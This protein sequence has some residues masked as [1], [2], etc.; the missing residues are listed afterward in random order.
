MGTDRQT[1]ELHLSPAAEPQSPGYAPSRSAIAGLLLALI[2]A[3]SPAAPDAAGDRATGRSRVDLPGPWRA[4][5]MSPG[6][7]LPFTLRF[8]AGESS[9]PAVA[10][11][12]QEEVPFS[13]VRIDGSRVVLH[14]EGYDSVIDAR[15]SND[16]RLLEGEWSRTSDTGRSRLPFRATRGDERRFT[17]ELPDASATADRAAIPS[18]AGT[19]SAR[20]VD[21]EGEEPARAEFRQD[22]TRVTGTFLLPTGDYRYLEGDYRDGFLRLSCFDGAHVFLFHARARADGY[23]EGDFWSRDTY[24]ATWTARP[25]GDPSVEASLPD[26]FEQVHLTNDEGRFS[27]RFPDLDGRDVTLP[28]QRFNGKVVV[29][30]LFGSWCPNCN[31]EAPL[32]ADWY[33]RYRDRGLEIVGLAYEF[34]GD[35]SRDRKFV[36]LFAERHGIE[37]TLLLAGT[38]D[39]SDAAETLPD[40]SAVKAWPTTLFIGRDGRVR[41]IYSGFA[42]PATGDSHALLVGTLE[43][44]LEEL[45]SEQAPAAGG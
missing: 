34:T 20:F 26:P 16:G 29:V 2:I 39:K 42:G 37:Y 25:L 38:S 17:G 43:E 40:L 30:N 6:G 15:L 35:E 18:V 31:D 27:F 4:V 11:N 8:A 22:G 3:C 23:L 24:H 41:K 19:W 32:L 5:L 33:R 10:V 1:V 7:E 14:I 36:R 13:A 21:E 44:L 12:G 45:L 28:G 9:P